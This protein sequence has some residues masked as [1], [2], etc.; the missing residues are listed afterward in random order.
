M[1]KSLDFQNFRGF[2]EG[3]IDIAPLTIITGPNNAGKSTIM[4]ALLVLKAIAA[5]T[6]QPLDSFFN[7]TF[8]NLGGFKE[9]VLNKNEDSRINLTVNS[10]S[11]DAEASYTAVLGKTRSRLEIVLTQPTPAQLAVE[12]SFPY[13]LNSSTGI[14]LDGLKV[15][16]NGITPTVAASPPP[17]GEP[18][19]AVAPTVLQEAL[20]LPPTDLK[21][22]DFVPLKRGFTKPIFAPQPQQPFLLSEDDVATFVANDRDLEGLVSYYLEL[23][24]EKNFQVRP[25]LGAASF[26]LQTID[27]ATGFV[28]DLVNDG[29]G[30]NALVYLLIKALRQQHSLICI[31]EPEIHIHPGA[32]VK[33]ARALGRIAKERARSFL[34]STH[35]EHLVVEILN[36]V[37]RGDI[38]PDDVRVYY[39]RRE[40]NRQAIEEQ[41]INSQGQIEGGLKSFYQVEL[42]QTLAF[43]GPRQ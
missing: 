34:L 40:R 18:G 17:A 30:T 41:S 37:A 35:S 10:A 39:V 14:D 27:R 26:F 5:N 43:L 31:E 19:P 16:W 9:C 24:V 1:I 42:E 2:R 25:V 13:A 8:M 3:H 11:P 38:A 33:L 6:N 36:A 23:I 28:C 20:S 12:T 29:F 32:L 7:F 21:A 15:T 22:I 4:Y